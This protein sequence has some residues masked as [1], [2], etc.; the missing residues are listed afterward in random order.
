[1]THEQYVIAFLRNAI[2]DFGGKMSISRA[3]ALACAWELIKKDPA[4]PC[5]ASEVAEA[6]GVSRPTASKLAAQL[7]E[8]GYVEPV[9]LEDSR[10]LG[11]RV[12]VAGAG[13]KVRA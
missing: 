9:E 13:R 6:A 7:V 1:M 3:L 11:L 8:K 2:Q 4:R 12:T 5:T 10:E